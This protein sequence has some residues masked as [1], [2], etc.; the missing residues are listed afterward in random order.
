M[1]FSGMNASNLRAARR[2]ACA[3]VIAVL[4]LMTA[5][6]SEQGNQRY[7]AEKKLFKARKLKDDLYAGG[8]K[9]EFL[10]KT[11]D[12]YRGIVSEYGGAIGMDAGLEEIVVSAQMELGELEYRGGL[13]REARADFEKA[14]ELAKNVPAARANALY[15][16]GVI[17]EDLGELAQAARYYE[18]FAGGFLDTDS[19]ASTVRMNQRYLV[20]PLKL[21]DLASRLGDQGGANRWLKEAERVF[22]YVSEH[23]KDPALLRETKYNLLATYLQ[24][25]SWSKGLE[26]VKEMKTQYR[27]PQDVSS[28]L[29]IEAKI[30]E[31]GL[32]NPSQA[33]ALY[34]SIADKY[35]QSRETSAAILAAAGIR[36]ATGRLDEAAKLYGKVIDGFKDRVPEV[37]EAEWQMAEIEELRGDPEAASLRYRSIYA[38]YPETLQGFEA[39]LRIALN[40]REHGSVDAAEASYDKALA[41]YEKLVSSQRPMTTRIMAE[42]YI[43]RTLVEARRWSEAC[44]RLLALCDRYPDYTPFRENYLRAASIYETELGDGEGAIRT[45]ETCVAKYPGTDIAQAADRELARLKR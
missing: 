27:D 22:S 18:R 42:Q 7:A 20:T 41:H 43:V 40:Y 39:P 19:L 16:A 23:E 25:K 13:L 24:Q 37:V 32:G 35:P 34:L 29:Y 6:S 10:S 33:M 3:V 12:A 36:K 5:C 44:N 38:D 31:D 26:Y 4:A 17:S 45:L 9:S 11:A 21:A 14:M 28:L 8:M 30:Y 1:S 15:S 2:V